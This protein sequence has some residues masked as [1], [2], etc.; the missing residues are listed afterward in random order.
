ML[1]GGCLC[2]AV[3]YRFSGSSKGVTICHCGMC[4]R[5]HG[6]PG[7]YVTGGSAADY[8]IEGESHLSWFQSSHDAERGFCTQCGSRLF[9]RTTDGATTEM[10]AGSVDQPTGLATLA[11]IWVPD[12]G[13]YYAI[14]DG[15]P[16]FTE[17]TGSAV[18]HGDPRPQLKKEMLE[19]SAHCLCGKVAFRIHGVIRDVVSCHCRQCQVSHGH[20]PGYTAA[21]WPSIEPAPTGDVAWYRSSDTARRGFCRHCG[22][23]LFW[24][25]A[26][27]RYV[28]INAGLLDLPT[29]LINEKHIF[30]D[31]KGDYY[32]IPEG[33]ACVPSSGSA[34]P[35]FDPAKPA[36]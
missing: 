11:H 17:G 36:F 35:A 1:Q 2:G 20:F 4:R 32:R 31:D 33:T 13:D 16:R 3:R 19:H 34:K 21:P 6:A 28:A 12:K 15:P 22:S 14:E 23:S 9:W 29:G 10:T 30:T 27:G 24:D 26:H 25:P 18:V 7:A 5:W 8:Q